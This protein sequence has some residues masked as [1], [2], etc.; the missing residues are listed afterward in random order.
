MNA[1]IVHKDFEGPKAAGFFSVNIA[2]ATNTKY[3]PSIKS[4]RTKKFYNKF[5]Y[6]IRKNVP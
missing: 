4:I 3:T 1:P 2:N 5:K 6:W